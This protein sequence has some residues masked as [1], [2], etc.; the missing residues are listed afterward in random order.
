MFT[1]NFG[2]IIIWILFLILLKYIFYF[3][4]NY[5]IV[6]IILCIIL[7]IF[8]YIFG[9]VL[10]LDNK[11]I[12]NDLIKIAIKFIRSNS[13]DI[14]LDLILVVFAYNIQTQNYGTS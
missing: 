9:T 12:W 5:N 4:S 14:S 8:H 10:I 3:Y 2:D 1:V 7:F 11:I 13:L 6:C